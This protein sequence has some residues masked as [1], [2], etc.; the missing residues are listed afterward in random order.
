[1]QGLHGGMFS[2]AKANRAKEQF[3]QRNPYPPFFFFLDFFFSGFFLALDS[4]A[5]G[6]GAPMF[7]TGSGMDTVGLPL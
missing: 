4:S 5:V 7:P 2:T 1:M 6:G 3:L